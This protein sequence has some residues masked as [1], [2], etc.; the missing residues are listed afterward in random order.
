MQSEGSIPSPLAANGID[1]TCAF[2]K[3]ETISSIL[4]ETSHFRL[5]TDV[6]PLVEGHLLIIP[7]THYACYGA[8]PPELDEEL[9]ALKQEV[10]NFFAQ[11][12]APPVFWEHGIFR[13]TVFHAH[14]HCFP[15]GVTAYNLTKEL[16][17]RLVHSQD[18]I[19]EWFRARGQYF[20]LEDVNLALIFEPEMGRYMYI[21]REVLWQGVAAR[22]KQSGWRSPAQRARDGVPLI[23]A[24][25]EKWQEFEQHEKGIATTYADETSSR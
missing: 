8:V 25:G 16:H 12:Y 23:Q 7:K 24:T 4:K 20:Y 18:D 9:F 21:I 11:Y 3:R 10:R 13:Q 1:P 22:S 19:R 14:L 5:A 2:C 17:T 6:A 15:F